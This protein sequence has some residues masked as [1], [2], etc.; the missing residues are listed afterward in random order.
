MRIEEL[1][2]DTSLPRRPPVGPS[3]TRDTEAMRVL[4]VN[5]TP[6]AAYLAVAE[7]DQILSGLPERLKPSSGMEQGA[8]L[9]EFISDVRNVLAQ[10]LPE[11]VV[12]LLAEIRE[13]GDTHQRHMPRITLEALVRVAVAQEDIPMELVQRATVRSRLS[14]S[15][16]GSLDIPVRE[17]VVTPVGR[18]WNDGR[19]LAALVA[20][21]GATG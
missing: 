3:E 1:F 17:G 9:L 12:L 4:G 10:V 19:G 16:T 2:P 18:Y 6:Q 21:T 13:R 7:G 8:R 20:L 15:K 14:L 11:R 5:C